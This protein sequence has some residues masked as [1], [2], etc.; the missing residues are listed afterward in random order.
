MRRLTTLGLAIA[1][2]GCAGAIGDGQEEPGLGDDD[3]QD[4]LL[5]PGDDMMRPAPPPPPS[6]AGA[7]TT[8][9][10]LRLRRL[11]RTE[12]NNTVRDLLGDATNPANGFVADEAVGAFANNI[13]ATV[14]SYALEQ[15][16]DAAEIVAT[17]AATALTKL[18]ACSP[19]I[20]GEDA[21]VTDFIRTFGR[22]AFR[23]PLVEAEVDALA[24]LSK[25]AWK[26]VGRTPPFADRI[27]IVVQAVLQSPTFL[28][29]PEVGQLVAGTK[30]LVRLTDYE[31][32]TRLSYLLGATAPDTALLDAAAARTLTSA[33]GLE[34]QATRLMGSAKFTDSLESFHLQWLDLE[35]LVGA[36]KDSTEF[37]EPVRAAMFQE[38]RLFVD[39]VIRQGDAKLQTLLTS[40]TAFVTPGLARVYRVTYPGNAATESASK[41]VDLTTI[42]NQRAGILTRGAFLSAQAHAATSSPV[43]RG[44]T[45]RERLLCQAMPPPP[46]DIDSSP[47]AP[48]P[49]ATTREVLEAQT[50]ASSCSGCHRLMNPIGFGFESYDAIGK[51]RTTDGGR[52]INTN[53][54]FLGGGADLDGAFKGTADMANRLANSEAV[55]SCVADKWLEFAVGRPTIPTADSCSLEKIKLGFASSGHDIRKLILAVIKSDA[56]LYGRRAP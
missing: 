14:G 23:R 48:R 28:Y 1:L 56:F 8:A 44:K 20:T 37:N 9:A 27:R 5:P 36:S 13:V 11:N 7:A 31:L 32:A 10:P 24:V 46:D 39:D 34:A 47:P 12:Y 2:A 41:K 22:R 45:V 42:D 21:C 52:P 40:R 50:M 51:L 33:A 4:P 54:E 53:G 49:G 6:C 55:R 30:D 29:R 25:S 15:F 35:P 26:D 19:M 17:K 18:T 3:Y 16:Q 38:T 43:F